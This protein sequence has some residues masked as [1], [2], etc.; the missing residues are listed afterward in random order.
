MSISADFTSQQYLDILKLELISIDCI[1][2]LSEIV[3]QTYTLES[4]IHITDP[5]YKNYL[6]EI[7]IMLKNINERM[8]V[9]GGGMEYNDLSGNVAIVRVGEPLETVTYDDIFY[10]RVYKYVRETL[11]G[12]WEYLD[13]KE[14]LVGAFNYYISQGKIKGE[15]NIEELTN[16]FRECIE[17]AAERANLY[18]HNGW[19]TVGNEE[20]EEYGRA[21]KHKSSRRKHKPTL[22][23]SIHSKSIQSK[24]RRSKARRSKA[25][26]NKHSKSNYD[27]YK[28]KKSKPKK[29]KRVKA[30]P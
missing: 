24:T 26:R 15:H 18:S 25:R 1:K 30:K 2:A 13:I 19:F 29:S 10:Y 28:G 5:K 23:K 17:S 27:K 20:E 16:A 9:Y 22:S 3:Y 8:K 21:P 14:I 7:K 11:D 12:I 4:Q 6:I